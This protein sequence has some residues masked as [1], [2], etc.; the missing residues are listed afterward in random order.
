MRA[1]ERIARVAGDW[2]SDLLLALGLS[3]FLLISLLAPDA[4]RPAAEAS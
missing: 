3:A 1:T 2:R 4:P